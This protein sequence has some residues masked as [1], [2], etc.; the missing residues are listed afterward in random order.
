MKKK[1]K[2]CNII[3]SLVEQNKSLLTKIIELI[4]VKMKKP[5]STTVTKLFRNII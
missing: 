2:N 4:F 5:S 3:V 1:M